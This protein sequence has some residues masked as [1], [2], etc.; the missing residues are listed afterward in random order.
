MSLNITCYIKRIITL[1]SASM[2]IERPAGSL[3]PNNSRR[4]WSLD[5]CCS[6]KWTN[7]LKWQTV[8]RKLHNTQIQ[9]FETSLISLLLFIYNYCKLRA[10]TIMI[11]E[12]ISVL[13]LLG[14]WIELNESW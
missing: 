8:N 14:N 9:T 10:I 3:W 5:W 13:Y 12:D 4:L 2:T 7:S 6:A 11:S 1:N